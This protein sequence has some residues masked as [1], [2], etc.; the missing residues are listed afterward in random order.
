MD[1]FQELESAIGTSIPRSLQ[2]LLDN[3]PQ[4]QAGKNKFL[5]IVDSDFQQTN[6]LQ[7][8]LTAADIQRVWN[9]VKTDPEFLEEKILPFAETLGS[10]LVCIGIGEVNNG[11]IFVFDY[12]FFNTKLAES[13]EKFLEM[14][15]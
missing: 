13:M 1:H 6:I 10:A 5:R 11:E 12:D 3:P 15:Y 7:N 9:N 2:K 14:L 8:F 4:I